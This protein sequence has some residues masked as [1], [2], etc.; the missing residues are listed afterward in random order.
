MRFLITSKPRFPFPP[1]AGPAL[2]AAMRAWVQQH[3]ISKKIETIWGFAA[4]GGGGGILNVD[5]HEEL[6]AVMAGMPF[7][8]VSEIHAEAIVPIEVSLRNLEEAMRQMTAG[9]KK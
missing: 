2:L 3:T 7:T 6:N 5:S 8:A 1:D 9:M 4:G